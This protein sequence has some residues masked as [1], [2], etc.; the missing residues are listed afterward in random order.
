MLELKK[1]I[2]S[3]SKVT[4]LSHLNPDGDAIGT[5]LGLYS[6]LKAEGKLVEIVNATKILPMHLNFLPNFS[7]IKNRVEFEEG[8]IIACDTGSLDRLGF[9]VTG[10]DILN[11]DHHQSNTHYGLHNIVKPSYVS[12]SCVAYEIF[13][14]EYQL[15]VDAVICFYT[16]LVS[17][18]QYFITNNVNKE[19]F[20]VT[21][22]MIAYGIN[23][24]KVAYNLNHR[25]SLSSLRILSSSLSSLKLYFS[26]RLSIVIATKEQ[27]KESGANYNDLVGIVDYGIS[28]A[29]VEISI[30]VMEVEEGIRVSL[31]SNKEID[32]ATLAVAC[33][34]GGHKNSSGFEYKS[35]NQKSPEE[36]IEMLLAKIK[37]MEL[38]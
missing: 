37:E 21:S 33:G 18:S 31:R 35:E 15:S 38:L 12:A 8:L 16:A 22:D 3:Y 25:K 34:G 20:D 7:K 13:K 19:V 4:I 36:A 14:P 17:D 30:C 27:I 28:L 2:D 11:I 5:S 10:R 26:G 32:V 9:D 23:I 29:T 24:S 6:I 1:I